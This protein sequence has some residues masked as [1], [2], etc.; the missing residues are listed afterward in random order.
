MRASVLLTVAKT[1]IVWFTYRCIAHA[2][3]IVV[4]FAGC[5][6]IN[7]KHVKSFIAYQR[8]SKVMRASVCPIL[9][10]MYIARRALCED[11]QGDNTLV[12][13]SMD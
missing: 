6:F 12:Y 2:H 3:V 11:I 9:L 10:L 8:S 7:V 13:Y 1:T 5:V 4:C